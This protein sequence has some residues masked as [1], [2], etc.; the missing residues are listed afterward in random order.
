MRRLHIEHG[1]CA[2]VDDRDYEWLRHFRWHLS[3]SG[4][5]HYAV[6]GTDVASG[7]PMHRMILKPPDNLSIDH[8]NGNGLDNRRANLRLATQQQNMWNRRGK[9]NTSSRFKGV[10]WKTDQQKWYAAIY[11]DKQDLHLGRF[12]DE[13][14]AARAYDAAAHEHFGG[15]ARLN[16]PLVR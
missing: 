8:I 10:S 2:V 12:D 11:V 4:Q 15:Y 14:E 9:R 6:A 1:L 5:R 7:M 3:R 16:F 13:M